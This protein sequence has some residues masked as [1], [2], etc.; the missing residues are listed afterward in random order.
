MPSRLRDSLE[1]IA[2]I[3]FRCWIIGFVLLG[4]GFA[5]TQ[6]AHEFIVKLHG[7]MFGLSSHEIDMIF[8]CAFGLIKLSVLICFFIPWLSIKLVMRKREES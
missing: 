6:L 4:I 1:L 5:G 2:A 8:Y 3:L 7:L